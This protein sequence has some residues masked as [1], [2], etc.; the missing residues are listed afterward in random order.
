MAH[1]QREMPL[2]IRRG[3][4][5]WAIPYVKLMRKSQLATKLIRPFAIARAQQI[6]FIEQ[7]REKGS[8]LGSMIR[9][10][11]EPICFLMGCFCKEADLRQ[12]NDPSLPMTIAKP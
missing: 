5:L 12:L 7:K 1:A 10:I 11:G 6:S 2:Q 9:L 4:H 3:Y 8:L